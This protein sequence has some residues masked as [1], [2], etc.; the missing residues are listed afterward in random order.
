V[1]QILAPRCSPTRSTPTAGTTT[2]PT[3]KGKEVERNKI[4]IHFADDKVTRIDGAA[5]VAIKGEERK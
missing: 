5:P 3:K 1:R 2:S 4:T